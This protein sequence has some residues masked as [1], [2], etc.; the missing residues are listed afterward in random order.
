MTYTNI[1]TKGS[2]DVHHI[3]AHRLQ[4]NGTRYEL[5]NTPSFYLGPKGVPNKDGVICNLEGDRVA[6]IHRIHPN[7]QI[8][9]FESLTD[10]LDA[11]DAYWDQYMSDLESHTLLT[12]DADMRGLGA[13]APPVMTDDGLL[14]FFHKTT[15][16]L[17]YYMY[18]ALL[19]P[20][21]GEVLRCLEYPVLVPELEWELYG[22]VD[23]VIFVQG[24][25]IQ[26]DRIYLAYG[27]ADAH[28]GAATASV[29]DVLGTLRHADE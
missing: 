24:I 17:A 21:T 5:E 2:G 13:G 12:C 20:E 9:V 6:L 27:A 11:D 8:A 4:W 19:S 10:L 29:Y 14:M 28:I 16:D 26:G 15:L 22:D 25:D 7:M 23:N 3:G 1:P 18:V